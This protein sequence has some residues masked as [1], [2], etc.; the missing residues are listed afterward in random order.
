M[1]AFSPSTWEAEAG[2]VQG[3]PG[4]QSEFQDSQVLSRREIK[5][6]WWMLASG[7]TLCYRDTNFLYEDTLGPCGWSKLPNLQMC[8]EDPASIPPWMLCRAEAELSS[9]GKPLSPAKLKASTSSLWQETA[10]SGAANW[11]NQAGKHW[12]GKQRQYRNVT[13]WAGAAT[14]LHST[15]KQKA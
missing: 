15:T 14:S 7:K 1:H 8:C 5:K 10:K 6:V 12:E 11:Q 9:H 13:Q 2:E 3:Q 4:L